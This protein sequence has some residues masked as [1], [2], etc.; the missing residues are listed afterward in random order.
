MKA[1]TTWTRPYYGITHLE[2]ADRRYRA[3]VSDRR[4]F[5]TLSLWFPGC[6]FSPEQRT[7]NSVAEAKSEGEAWL[8]SVERRRNP[9]GDA[10]G[11]R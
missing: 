2:S 6:G 3:T 1:A 9:Q 10:H 11:A 8:G 7:A 4:T 5:V